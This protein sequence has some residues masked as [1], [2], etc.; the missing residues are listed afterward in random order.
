MKRIKWPKWLYGIGG[1]IFLLVI[2]Y[3]L[4]NKYF[5]NYP[6]CYYFKDGTKQGWTLDQFYNSKTH[7]QLQ[8]AVPPGL[9]LYKPFKL[10]NYQNLGLEANASYVLAV[11]NKND[12]CE[13]Y[14]DS[15][16]L[17]KNSNWQN[18]KGLN[19]YVKRTFTSVCGDSATITKNGKKVKVL[20]HFAQIQLVVYDLN[21]NYKEKTFGEWDAA[22]NDFLF[23]AVPFNKALKIDWKPSFLSDPKGNYKIKKIRVRCIMPGYY[24]TGECPLS[25]SWWITDVCPLK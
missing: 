18:I 15:P 25:G 13:I 6:G 7:K 14:F 19:L 8:V 22:K 21:D 10:S 2:G 12:L 9:I 3:F 11:N 20:L 4:F 23:H 1:V 16:D 24:L 5:I 17:T